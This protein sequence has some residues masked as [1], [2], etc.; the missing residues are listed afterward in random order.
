[1]GKISV[2]RNLH[3]GKGDALNDKD[4]NGRLLQF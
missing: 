1:V 2:K 4:Y 3:I